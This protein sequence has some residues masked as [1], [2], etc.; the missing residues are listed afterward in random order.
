MR[1]VRLQRQWYAETPDGFGGAKAL[2]LVP[3]RLRA[4]GCSQGKRV[5]SEPKVRRSEYHRSTEFATD[6]L[7]TVSHTLEFDGRTCF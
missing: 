1:D 6:P 5:I 2:S 4:R 3:R 7:D